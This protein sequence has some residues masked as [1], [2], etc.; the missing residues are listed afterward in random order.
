MLSRK[1]LAALRAEISLT[2]RVSMAA[3]RTRRGLAWSR[4]GN[5][6][7]VAVRT[8]TRRCGHVRHTSS[9]NRCRALHTTVSTL[10]DTKALYANRRADPRLTQI[11][12]NTRCNLET[13]TKTKSHGLSMH[14]HADIL[15]IHNGAA[16]FSMTLK[17]SLFAGGVTR[18]TFLG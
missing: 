3:C 10:C 12:P 13:L 15:Q 11:Q 7:L 4:L 2:N 5:N 14:T 8:R 18:P 6:S 1:L 17:Y 9:G 16:Y